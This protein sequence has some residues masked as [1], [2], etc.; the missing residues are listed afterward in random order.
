MKRTHEVTPMA[1]DPH[2]IHVLLA[3]DNGRTCGA[4][5]EML[6]RISSRLRE[7]KLFSVKAFRFG[8]LEQ[9]DPGKWAAANPEEAE[10]AVVAF[11]QTG[12]PGANLLRWLENWAELHAGQ[13]AALGL[14]PMGTFTGNSMRHVVQSLRKI[15]A[16][17]GLGFIY[18]ADSKLQ[19][20][21]EACT[22]VA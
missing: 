5:L 6:D 16:R 1:K 9:M 17:H 13:N 11:G 3:Y 14:L 12:A 7:K 20:F 15:A 10:L 8:L 21:Q 2:S 19:P 4:I 22:V 18:G